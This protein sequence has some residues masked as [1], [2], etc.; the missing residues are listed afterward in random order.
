M[1]FPRKLPNFTSREIKFPR[2]FT[3]F[4][5]REIKFPRKLMMFYIRKIK[6]REKNDFGQPRNFLPAKISSLT[7]YLSFVYLVCI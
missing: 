6:F 7:V 4:T 5:I 1:K 3:N 2:K